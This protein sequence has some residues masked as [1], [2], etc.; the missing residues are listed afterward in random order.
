[1]RS[2][3]V[4]AGP[5]ISL[6]AV[7][8]NNHQHY[9]ELITTLSPLGLR[10]ITTWPCVVEASYILDVTHR[11]EMLHWI[12]IGGVIVYPFGPDD[13]APLTELMKKYTEPKKC[14]M[15]FADA[16]LYWL[17]TET[18]ITEIM[19]TDHRD[20]SRYRLPDNTHFQIL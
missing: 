12:E 20:F 9:D 5:I 1:M 4:D 13:L 10:L 15:D 16:S 11:F 6:F 3:I 19:T 7:D 17:A 8:D 2:I 18:G 14:E